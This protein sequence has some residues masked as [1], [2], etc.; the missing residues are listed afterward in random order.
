MT[1]FHHHSIMAPKVVSFS[2]LLLAASPF[3][4]GPTVA[5]GEEQRESDLGEPTSS[6]NDKT[7]LERFMLP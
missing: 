7:S 6:M 5:P 1:T 4:V 3:I 2:L